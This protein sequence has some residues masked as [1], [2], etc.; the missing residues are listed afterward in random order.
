[1][2]KIWIALAALCC[3]FIG[4][5]AAEGMPADG[6]Y[7]PDAVTFTGG[8]GRVQITCPQVTVESGAATAR[9]VFSS[10]NYECVAVDGVAYEG[11]HTEN[12]SIFEVPAPLNRA[13]EIV[14]RTTA[15]SRPH[16]IAYTLYIGLGDAGLPG[17]EWQGAMALSYAE[18]FSVDYYSENFALITVMD[19]ARYLVV[20]EGAQAPEGL[21]PSIAV[22]QKPLGKVYLAASS[23]MALVDRL[24]ALDAVRFSALQPDAWT[25]EHAAE[26]MQAGRILYAGKYSEPDYEL[27]LLEGCDI[28]VENTMLLHTP[29]VRELIE[30]LGIPVFID[31][32]SYEPH[33]LGRLEW[34]RLYGLLLDRAAEA[35]AFFGEQR[36]AVEAIAQ[37]PSTG[38]TVAFFY[39]HTDG[40]AVV[41]GADD[42]I[43]RMIGLGGGVYA[44]SDM[45]EA[46]RSRAAVHLTMEDFYAE[47]ADADYLIYNA[48]IDKTVNSLGDLLN[49][50]PL[51][52]DFEAV[53]RG[54]LFVA[55]DALYQAS[56]RAAGLILDVHAMLGGA[57]E[58]MTFLQKLD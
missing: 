24:D 42:Y 17:L 35:E 49:R 1:M 28:A 9:V 57:R 16:D 54:R 34:I 7:V 47:A 32:S 19:G 44:F 3:L 51:F 48:A 53:K 26:A 25:V 2:R 56:D 55:G 45:D 36:S 46:S 29:K 14:G 13:F 15:M 50:S 37:Q 43:A 20:P 23:A 58:G 5:A 11:E 41:R 38:S 22:L 8:S 33:P 31:Y 12:A 18:C 39:L 4:C 30:L 6:V 10:P 27:L 40:T 52:Q 21:E